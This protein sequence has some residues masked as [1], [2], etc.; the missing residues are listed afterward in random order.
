MPDGTKVIVQPRSYRRG[1]P[2]I[3]SSVKRPSGLFGAIVLV[4]LLLP[5]SAAPVAAA[6]GAAV[7]P[8]FRD[9]AVFTGLDHPMS[10]VVAAD[11][12]VFVAE[13]HGTSSATR[14]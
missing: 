9:E 1:L 14:A 10:V 6:S 13:K 11:G 12:S 5:F 8:A 4:A 2:T 3:C 7:P